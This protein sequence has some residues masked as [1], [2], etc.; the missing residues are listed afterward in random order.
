[1]RRF[2]L[3]RH[4]GLVP[5]LEVL[6]AQDLT[7][8]RLVGLLML[9]LYRSGRQA[10][11]LA[12]YRAARRSLVEELGLEPG[13]ELR[14]LE[15]AVLAH[16]PALDLPPRPGP[17][18]AAPVSGPSRR[19]PRPVLAV[20]AVL[21]AAAVIASLV[22]TGGSAG[23]RR[24][25][26]ADGAGA[27]DLVTGRVAASVPVGYAP[28]GIAAG[29]GSIWMTNGADGTVTRIDPHGPHV[30]QTLLVGTSPAGVAYGRGGLGRQ[31]ARWK[32]LPARPTGQSGGSDDQHRPASD[33]SGGRRGRGM[34]GR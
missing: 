26:A 8:E 6:V 31:R 19:R 13:P 12:A 29:A 25:I 10:D 21:L 15:A 30:E 28:A 2:E 9:A 23:S 7:R 34:G 27:L 1:M 32:C 3:G 14:R 20:A 5:E 17:Q 16:D 33:R 24:V 11:A 22:L 18:P 4:S